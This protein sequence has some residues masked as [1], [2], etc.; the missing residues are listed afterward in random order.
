LGNILGDFVNNSSGHPE[1][2]HLLFQVQKAVQYKYLY[3]CVA[4]YWRSL[5]DEDEED[6]NYQIYD[7]NYVYYT[8]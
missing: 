6:Y 7:E 4:K 2:D 8:N 1:P 5:D 3:E